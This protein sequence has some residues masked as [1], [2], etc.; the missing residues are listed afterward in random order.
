MFKNAEWHFRS[1]G[2]R[3][4]C[5]VFLGGGGVYCVAHDVCRDC[6]VTLW[7]PEVVARWVISLH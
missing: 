4:E 5:R 7:L 2:E 1:G 3:T 6:A